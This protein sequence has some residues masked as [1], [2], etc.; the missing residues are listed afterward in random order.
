MGTTQTQP[1]SDSDYE[2]HELERLP[3]VMSLDEERDGERDTLV[4]RDDHEPPTIIAKGTSQ[5]A[6]HSFVL[7]KYWAQGTTRPSSAN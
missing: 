7:L 1:A 6:D 2:D 4:A 5:D 3:S